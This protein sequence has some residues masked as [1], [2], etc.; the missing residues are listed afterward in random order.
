MIACSIQNCPFE[1]GIHPQLGQHKNRFNIVSLDGR[2]LC[3]I[4]L[5][6]EEQQQRFR[7]DEADHLYNCISKYIISTDNQISFCRASFLL[8]LGA[9]RST[10]ASDSTIAFHHSIFQEGISLS[11]SQWQCPVNFHGCTFLK[12]VRFSQ[13]SMAGF[14]SFEECEFYEG[15]DFRTTKMKGGASFKGSLFNKSGGTTTFQGASVDGRSSF[16]NAKFY[17]DVDFR[18]VKF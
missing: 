7:K 8:P 9:F 14:V 12:D 16:S 11:G 15:V 18:K 10:R 6:L 1:T 17:Q 2:Y 4:H 3:P 13:M 5:P